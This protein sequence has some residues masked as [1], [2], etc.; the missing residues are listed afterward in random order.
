MK[1]VQIT[2]GLGSKRHASLFH[3]L[4]ILILIS[5][6]REQLFFFEAPLAIYDK[7]SESAKEHT[8]KESNLLSEGYQIV[9]EFKDEKKKMLNES[10]S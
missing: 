6:I 1:D 7:G 2:H 10:I 9:E 3:S 8:N 4:N 5:I